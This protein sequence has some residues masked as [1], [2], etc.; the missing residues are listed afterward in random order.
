M[1]NLHLSVMLLIALA[2]IQ[3]DKT[4]I[5]NYSHC[6]CRVLINNS[7]IIIIIILI[8]FNLILQETFKEFY[9]IKLIHNKLE[10]VLI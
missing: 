9:M 5:T 2:G 10:I 1:L 7:I 3:S 8:I 4:Y 6:I